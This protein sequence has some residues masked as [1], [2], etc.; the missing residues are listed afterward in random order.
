MVGARARV[1]PLLL[2][3]QKPTYETYNHRGFSPIHDDD[4]HDSR[5]TGYPL[6]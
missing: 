2:N 3:L 5:G 6:L 1:R 4:N